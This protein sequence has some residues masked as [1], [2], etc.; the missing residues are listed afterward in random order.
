MRNEYITKD[1]LRIEKIIDRCERQV[2]RELKRTDPMFI[3][4]SIVIGFEA[5][6]KESQKQEKTHK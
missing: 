1:D 5:G 3:R 2:K 6:E 4:R